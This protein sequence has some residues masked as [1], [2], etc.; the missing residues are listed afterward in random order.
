VTALTA[1]CLQNALCQL[2]IE[3]IS[4]EDDCETYEE[5]H[6]VAMH[7]RDKVVSDVQV[8]L[9]LSDVGFRDNTSIGLL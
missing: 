7:L 8:T 6:N 2:L 9:R 1:A 5:Q 3:D 4:T